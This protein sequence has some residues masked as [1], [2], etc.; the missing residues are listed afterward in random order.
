MSSGIDET[1]HQKNRL[2]IMAHLAA[3]GES[4]F[5]TLKKILG[6]TDGNLSVHSA[7]LE[8][9]GLIEAEKSFVGKKTRTVLK[10]TPDGRKAFEAYLK[11]LENLLRGR[12]S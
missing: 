8:E 9:K 7:I 10:I 6:L 11:E 3:V 4:D 12:C 5:L 1:I 2:A